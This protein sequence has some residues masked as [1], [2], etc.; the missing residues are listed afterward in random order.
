MSSNQQ[1]GIWPGDTELPTVE[2]GV[3][4]LLVKK[5]RKKI[6]SVM[7]SLILWLQQQK[8]KEDGGTTELVVVGTW[9]VIPVYCNVN[10][11]FSTSD[12]SK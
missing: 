10:K 2:R 7:S 11:T 12:Y 3:I 6:F 5:T 4:M 1:F 9:N 8:R